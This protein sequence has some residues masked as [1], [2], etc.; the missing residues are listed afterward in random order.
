MGVTSL[1]FS[2]KAHVVRNTQL[3]DFII[4]TAIF[5]TLYISEEQVV[6]LAENAGTDPEIAL[7]GLHA[8]R[9]E[10]P[11]IKVLWEKQNGLELRNINSLW[12]SGSV[13]QST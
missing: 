1:C 8:D 12:R 9:N 3:S 5:H 7:I 6:F 2:H 10:N 11:R 13:N 4:T